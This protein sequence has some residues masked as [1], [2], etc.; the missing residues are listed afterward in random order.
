MSDL[1]SGEE[2]ESAESETE[3]TEK[4]NGNL[5]YAIS[6]KSTFC[7]F[8]TYKTNTLLRSKTNK[9]SLHPQQKNL[10]KKSHQQTRTA[11]LKGILQ[12]VEKI[13]RKTRPNK[14]TKTT[15][16]RQYISPKTTNRQKNPHQNQP[17]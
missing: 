9:I 7:L 6:I 5:K 14:V 2:F 16:Y 17:Q 10:K 8:R 15:M 13:K 3:L 12:I 1:E 11:H 4:V